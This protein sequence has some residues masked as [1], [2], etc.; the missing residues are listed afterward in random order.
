MIVGEV[1]DRL[2]FPSTGSLKSFLGGGGEDC[3]DRCVC[4]TLWEGKDDGKL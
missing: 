3:T 2:V 1:V 4:F